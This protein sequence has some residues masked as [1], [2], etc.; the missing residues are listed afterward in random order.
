MKHL[1][2]IIIA[3]CA[4]NACKE[5]K[6][7]TIKGELDDANGLKVTL[8]KITP[9]TVPVR[10]DSC[11]IKKGKFEMKGTLEYPEYCAI[12]A[13]D[14][15]PLL[16]FVENTEIDI[17]FNLKN[18]QDSEVTGS[19]ETDLFVEYSAKITEFEDSI[20]KINDI[21]KID[22]IKQQRIEYVKHFAQENPNSIVTA[23]VVDNNL[24]YYLQPE[25]LE[26]YT[27]SLNVVSRESSWVR[28]IMKKVEIAKRIETGQPFVDIKMPAPD[29]SEISLSDHA[30]KGKYL[31]IDFWASWCPPCR[32]ANPKLVKLYEKYR[33]KGF[34]I[35]G[36]SLD[37]DKSQWKKAIE[38]DELTWAQMSDL[39][40]WQ[41]KAAELYSVTSIPYTVLLDK[42]GVIIAKGLQTDELE[43]KLAEIIVND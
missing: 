33:D 22:S 10:I 24:L 32:R 11:I 4:L 12:Y 39:E 8:L 38:A 40:Y 28:S 1:I 37:R 13:G 42:D 29:G 31:L 19:K 18:M 35:V 5:H 14:N 2:W 27:D 16:L 34:E 21:T 17:T 7:Y 20:A 26:F 23:F 30:G 3:V 15:G 25:D 6:G 41:S 9:D 43:E 36:I